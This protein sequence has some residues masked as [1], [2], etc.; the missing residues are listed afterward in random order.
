[1]KDQRMFNQTQC[2]TQQ[3]GV[4]LGRKNVKKH[5]Q[6]SDLYGS[7]NFKKMVNN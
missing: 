2:T 4:E 5:P 6:I 7:L 3:K 1:M